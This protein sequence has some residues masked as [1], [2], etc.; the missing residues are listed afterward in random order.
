MPS[1]NDTL[2][3]RLFQAA[4]LTVMSKI[5]PPVRR[6]RDLVYVASEGA[7]YEYSATSEEAASDWVV[8]PA[9]GP[10]RFVR[11]E[12]RTQTALTDAA[13][14]LVDAATAQAAA[15][16]AQATADAVAPTVVQGRNLIGGY[17]VA[18]FNSLVAHKRFLGMTVVTLDAG[19][20]D[21]AAT[22]PAAA[23]DVWTWRGDYWWKIANANGDGFVPA[24]TVLVMADDSSTVSVGAASGKLATFDGT[25]N[26]PTLTTPANNSAVRVVN[27]DNPFAAQTARWNSLFNSQW[28]VEAGPNA[29]ALYQN[30]R[31]GYFRAIGVDVVTDGGGAFAGSSWDPI[32]HG[33]QPPQ[34]TVVECEWTIITTALDVA[35]SVRFVVYQGA[36]FYDILDTG[37]MS[38]LGFPLTTV[39]KA[40]WV[41]HTPGDSYGANA[42]VIMSA[43]AITTD[44]GGAVV[45]NTPTR[46]LFVDGT[47]DFGEGG[48]GLQAYPVFSVPSIDNTSSLVAVTGTVTRL[49]AANS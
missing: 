47:Y 43:S 14:A 23:G 9:D 37:D 28:A 32:A 27:P 46:T 49:P 8:V 15:E 6:D 13:T 29:E 5:G 36:A 30:Q 31:H 7:V 35:S 19:T 24:G 2:A 20:L 21:P 48:A 42:S 25:S 44:N 34:G 22:G 33:A 41:Y 38:S 40:R 10:G 18:D 45:N 11:T 12:P 26:T 3:A 39:V 16:A 17:T 4:D 1:I